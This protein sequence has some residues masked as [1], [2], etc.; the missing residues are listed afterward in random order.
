MD[1][2]TIEY[3]KDRFAEKDYIVLSDRYDGAHKDLKC[4]CN[5]GHIFYLSWQKFK[6]GRTCK[7]CNGS[8]IYFDDVKKA[9]E[10]ENYT[11]LT[12]KD[13]YIGSKSPLCCMCNKGHIF[14]TTWSRWLRGSRCKECY[15]VGLRVSKSEITNSVK[16]FGYEVIEFSD[17]I[18]TSKSKFV[19][20]CSCGHTYTTDWNIWHRGHRCKLCSNKN[21]FDALKLSFSDVKTAVESEGYKLLSTEYINAFDRLELECPKAHKYKV[22]WN[23]WQQ[24]N[25]CPKCAFV[26]SKGQKEIKLFLD[27]IGVMSL[28]NDR[29]IISPLELDIVIPNKKIAIEYCGLYWHSEKMGKNKNY[30]L[31]KLKLC[32]ENGYKLITI[33]EDEWL[34]KQDIVKSRLKHIISN[35][36][37]GFKI[38]ARNCSISEIDSSTKNNFLDKNHIQGVD[39]SIIKLGAFC[40]NE[41]VS[42]MTF[43]HGN[44]AKGSKKEKG[45]WELNRFCSKLDHSVIGIASKLLKYFKRN[46]D[47]SIIFSYADRRWSV[48]ELYENIGFEFVGCTEPNYWYINGSL[49]RIHRFTLRK[50]KTES[51]AIPE[52]IIRLGEGYS[53]LWDCGSL[54]YIIK[55]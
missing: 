34:N 40:N 49:K 26:E 31:N 33:F 5:N 23:D 22:R 41:L 13:S 29:S 43:S 50:Q 46:Y 8:A 1:K 53:R 16:E 20:R 42:V 37:S 27:G 2:Y 35:S 9:L 30:H 3:I 12:T 51:S 52:H 6:Q 45:I 15:F 54:K 24:G 39:N 10:L 4:I 17:H 44:I 55:K 7:Y 21:R 32:E 47:W 25:R 48:G 11:L 36:S 18:V 28:E 19:V 38:Y 14:T